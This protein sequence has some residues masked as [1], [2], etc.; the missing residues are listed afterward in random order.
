LPVKFAT[1]A[2]IA[3][4]AGSYELNGTKL[5]VVVD[6]KRLYLEGPGEPRH[7]L[8]PISEREFWIESL[9]SLAVVERDGDKV[10]R[11]VFGIGDRT[12]AAPRVDA[13]AK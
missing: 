11:L 3:P 5:Q 2:Q 7:R 6:G 10:T 9:Q 1:A 12:L 4:L 13:D 8:A